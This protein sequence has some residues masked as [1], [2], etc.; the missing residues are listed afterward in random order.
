MLKLTI[1]PKRPTTMQKAKK[2]ESARWNQ[3]TWGIATIHNPELYISSL[4]GLGR[5]KVFFLPS[6]IHEIQKQVKEVR[7]IIYQKTILER[8]LEHCNYLL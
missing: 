5:K 7:D 2:Q 6:M 8:T 4:E 3:N 1:W